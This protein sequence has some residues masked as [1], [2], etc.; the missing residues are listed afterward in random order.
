VT[1]KP[2]APAGPPPTFAEVVTSSVTG[3]FA[4]RC[5]CNAC[6]RLLRSFESYSTSSFSAL[7]S[8]ALQQG[9]HPPLPALRPHRSRIRLHRRAQRASALCDHLHNH[10]P[11]TTRPPRRA[12]ARFEPRRERLRAG[13]APCLLAQSQDAPAPLLHRKQN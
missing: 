2:T 4:G 11:T 12:A 10:H 3:Q 7:L 8:T 6:A 13:A 9:A 5:A 1:T